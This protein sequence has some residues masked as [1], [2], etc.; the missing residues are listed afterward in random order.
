MISYIGRYNILHH[1]KS[2]TYI[3]IYYI[4]IT[5]KTIYGKGKTEKNEDKAKQVKIRL[6]FY[7]Q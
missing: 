5:L 7:C 2:K 4:K 6:P 1:I 3:S